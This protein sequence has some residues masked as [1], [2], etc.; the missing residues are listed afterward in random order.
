MN[1]FVSGAA[2][3]RQEVHTDFSDCDSA[4]LDQMWVFDHVGS[5][6]MGLR[7]FPEAG[8]NNLTTMMGVGAARMSDVVDAKLDGWK[9]RP[10]CSS[11]T[12]R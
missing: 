9:R 5:L 8:S 1:T 7:R 10:P 3:L 11:P 12:L 6:E 4:L 2:A